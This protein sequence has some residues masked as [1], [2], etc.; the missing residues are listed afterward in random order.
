MLDGA[1]I[2]RGLVKRPAILG[3]RGH[4]V[5]MLACR[6]VAMSFF[7]DPPPPPPRPADEL[8]AWFRPPRGRIA[9]L[10]GDRR[11]LA[12]GDDAV[13]LL[14]HVDVLAEGCVLRVRASLRRPDDMD[15]EQWHERQERFHRERL[16][17]GG[18]V[19]SSGPLRFGVAFA[20]GR[21]ATTD[22]WRHPHEDAP[23]PPSLQVHGGSSS[24]SPHHATANHPLWLW[25]LPPP[26]PFDLVH[27]WRDL[28]LPEQRTTLDGAAIVAAA[29]RSGPLFD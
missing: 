27:E 20:D 11:V 23:E 2:A 13:V 7:D 9:A 12:R 6:G 8:P 5:A 15:E 28:G 17:P 16:R 24:G 1:A 4:T 18:P 22:H 14:S 29:E 10:V 3:P 26:E 25:P 21:R 19:A